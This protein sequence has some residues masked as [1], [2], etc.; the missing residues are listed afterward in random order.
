VDENTAKPLFHAQCFQQSL[1]FGDG[2]LD[3]AG[4][5]V[6]KAARLGDRIE[7]LVNDF[8]WKSSA[9]TELSRPLA[10]LFL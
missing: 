3:I 5:Q 8:L 6:G 7:N 10:R 1:L 9:L 2:K 4:D